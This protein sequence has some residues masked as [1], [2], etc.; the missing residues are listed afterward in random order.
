LARKKLDYF[1]TPTLLLH[2]SG[3][4]TFFYGKPMRRC[5]VVRLK[6]QDPRTQSLSGR[7]EHLHSGQVTQ[8]ESIDEMVEFFSRCLESEKAEESSSPSQDERE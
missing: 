3:Y 1:F 2:A 6:T 7:V 4:F 8:F 5:F